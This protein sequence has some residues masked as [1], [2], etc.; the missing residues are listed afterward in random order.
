MLLCVCPYFMRINSEYRCQCRNSVFVALL[1]W[2][3]MCHFC[4]KWRRQVCESVKRSSA[5]LGSQ[6]ICARLNWTLWSWRCKRNW[7]PWLRRRKVD[8]V[9]RRR[10]RLIQETQSCP[11]QQWVPQQ[12]HSSLGPRFCSRNGDLLSCLHSIPVLYDLRYQGKLK[13]PFYS[14]IAP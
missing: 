9:L 12:P 14:Y 1:C 6:H 7:P 4:A 2:R 10:S 5:G 3:G 11:A 8:G 13:S